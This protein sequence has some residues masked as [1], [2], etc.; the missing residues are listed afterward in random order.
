[1]SRW[2]KYEVV[3]GLE[4]HAQLLTSSKAFS[5]D[6]NEYG[7]SPNTN[8]SVVSLGHPGTLPR[9]NEKALELAIRLGIAVDATINRETHYARKN[10]FYAD[11]PKGY[12]ITQFPLPVCT[13]GAVTV[14]NSQGEDRNITID[15]V[16]LEE[17]SGK[18]IHDLD[19]FSSLVDLNRAGVPL[20]EIVTG[21]DFREPEEAYNYLTEIRRLVRYLDICDG[22]M[23][24]GSLRCDAN[25][26]IRLVGQEEFGTKVEVKNMNSIRNVQRALE[27][28]IE[29]QIEAVE[30]GEKIS[31]ETRNFDAMTGTT[32]AMRGKEMAHDYRYFPEPDIPPM[33][34]TQDYIRQV[35]EQMP[36]LPRV[37][38]QR[39]VE[40]MGLNDY[41]A[42]ILTADRDFARYFLHVADHTE[43]YKA[44][45][46]WMIG[47]VRSYLNEQG[48][49]I[50]EFPLAPGQVAALVKLVES[51]KVSFSL[52]TQRVFPELMEHPQEEPE[53]V[54]KRLNVMQVGDEDFLYKLAEEAIQ[55][56]PDK[57]E[58]YR[59]G[60]K[61][62]LGLFMGEVMKASKGKADP[63]KANEIVRRVLEG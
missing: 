39:F 51:G 30:K 19:P 38:F 61:N 56:F 53:A 63:K 36:E 47:P 50:S 14:K 33:R 34:I 10:Y 5:D 13:D 42:G 20:V 2:G 57:A 12:Q 62:L 40:Q 31:Q 45:T 15:K 17:D 23:E 29:R 27:Y 59:S 4:V 9:P 6:P 60:K 3:I 35:Q 37:L 22:N 52:A 16:I 48:K 46:N 28:E 58:A 43:N 8:V 41:D 24:E 18:S 26:S 21:P 54:A 32:V 44:A 11:L 49:D 55:K 1:M 7:S 25:V